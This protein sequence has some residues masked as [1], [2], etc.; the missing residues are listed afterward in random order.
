MRLAFWLDISQVLA[1]YANVYELMTQCFFLLKV[2]CIISIKYSDVS[3][4]AVP[5]VDT[6]V[7]IG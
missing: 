5:I 1:S 3:Y 2:G 7:H 4:D 6:M